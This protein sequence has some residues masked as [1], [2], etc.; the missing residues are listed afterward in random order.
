MNEDRFLLRAGTWSGL[1]YLIVFG[2]GWLVL[3]RFLPPIEP[4]AGAATVAE[5]YRDHHLTLTL[6][7]VCIMVSTVVVLPVSALLVRIMVLIER[8]VGM[9]TLMMGF[10][11]ATFLVLN[12]YSGFSFATAAFR[13]ERSPEIVQYANDG[14]FLQ[15]M[16]GIPMFVMIWVLLA[17]AVLVTDTREDP[18][19]PRWVGYLNLWIAVLYLPELLVFV[20]KTG[21]FAWDGLIGFWIPAILFIA[22]F[23]ASP[24]VLRPVVR[25]HFPVAA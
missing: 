4:S 11:L 6:A 17:Y 14:G 20:F 10:S 18:V 9:L 1:A 13:S 3:A 8:G 25:R 5:H 16:G 2:T 22:F 19:L 7:A 15:F 12:F 24:F 21:P 23:L